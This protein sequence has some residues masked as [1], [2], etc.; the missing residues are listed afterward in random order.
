MEQSDR[1][2]PHPRKGKHLNQ[3]ERIQ[4]EVLL[5]GGATALHVA[6]L[7][8]R[9]ERTIRRERQRGWLTCRTGRDSAEERYNAV[10]GQTV[11]ERRRRKP[12][13]AA[14]GVSGGADYGETLFS[15]SG[16]IP[17]ER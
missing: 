12:A 1:S 15:G 17:D 5:R 7:L 10:R 11:Y 14:G 16:G 8:G 2:I 6:K 4:I 9:S 3:E 13:S